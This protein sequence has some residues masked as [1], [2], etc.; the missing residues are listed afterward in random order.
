M[1]E[2]NTGQSGEKIIVT[3]TEL[4]TL[5]EPYYLFRFV[6]VVTK[7][8]VSFIKGQIDDESDYP[9]RYNQFDIDT[10]VIF[11]NKPVGEWHYEVYE[12]PGAVNTDPVLATTLLEKGKMLLYAATPFEFETYNEPVTFKTYNG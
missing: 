6:H 3:L 5:D 9:S 4:Q 2:L 1:L 12:Q 7:Q 8:V 10:A 11:L